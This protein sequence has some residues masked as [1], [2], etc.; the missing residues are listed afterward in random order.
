MHHF[1]AEP[2]DINRI[3]RT[4]VLRGD[5]YRHLVQVLRGRVGEKI[6]ISDGD[7]TDYQCEITEILPE[8]VALH[9]DFR[10]EMHEL[11]A[12]IY[13]FQGLPKSDKM[14]LIVQKA[15]ELGARAI[16]PLETKNT[17]VKLDSRK[18]ES[19]VKRWQA[20][21]EAAAK[22]SKRS[23]I[24]EVLPVMG[25]RQAMDYVA[26]FSCRLIPYENARD[27]RR[28][29]AVLQRLVTADGEARETEPKTLARK[30]IGIFI[31]PEGGFD[32]SEI[33]AALEHGIV[34]V[35]LGKRILRTETAA[36]CAL[37]IVMLTL[38]SAAAETGEL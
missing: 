32:D 13:L 9:I 25:W 31:G 2:G 26:D 7:G 10:E 23:V 30:K 4:A 38:E 15:V 33:Q 1:F 24:P 34:P 37:S 17:V 11:P 20:I 14:E 6:L 19:K 8:A 36:I 12:D 5:N 35:T 29:M 27:I 3:E 21:A 28:T 18:S 22:Q 16:V